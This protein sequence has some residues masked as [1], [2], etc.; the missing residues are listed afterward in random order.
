MSVTVNERSTG[1]SAKT[2]RIDV[3]DDAN[4]AD[5]L[6]AGLMVGVVAGVAPREAAPGQLGVSQH[7]HGNREHRQQ[8]E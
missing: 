3:G 1:L 7:Q 8:P 4:V 5:A 6:N 2:N